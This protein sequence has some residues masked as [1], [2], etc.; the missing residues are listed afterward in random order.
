MRMTAGLAAALVISLLGPSTAH[1]QYGGDRATSFGVRAGVG[2]DPTQLV[3]GA[4]LGVGMASILQ[5]VPSVDVGFGDNETNI[6]FNGDFFARVVL[7]DADLELYGGGGPTLMY[8]DHDSP[9]GSDWEL[10]LSLVVGSRLPV[11]DAVGL[12]L[13]GRVGIADIPDFRILL[14]IVF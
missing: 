7:P 8:R 1:A 6:A 13:Q 11:S 3:L 10:G 2:F 14:A 9:A 4:Q 5:V 12:D